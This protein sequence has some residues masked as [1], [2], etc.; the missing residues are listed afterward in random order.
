MFVQY[1]TKRKRESDNAIL[2]SLFAITT[3]KQQL[4]FYFFFIEKNFSSFHVCV[5]ESAKKLKI[6][7]A[8]LFRIFFFLF[9]LLTLTFFAHT[10]FCNAGTYDT[11]PIFTL[12]VSHS[13]LH[14]LFTIN[15]YCMHGVSFL[16]YI[17]LIRQ[18]QP[19]ARAIAS[20]SSAR[21]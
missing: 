1:I 20:S 16:L 10:L 6:F 14:S 4:N 12:S 21:K 11:Q 19:A 9:F 3:N 5:K 15:T 8:I 13:L 7:I 2:F 18:S 17:F